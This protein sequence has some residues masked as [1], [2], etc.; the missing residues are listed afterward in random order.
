MRMPRIFMPPEPE[1]PP[2]RLRMLRSEPMSFVQMIVQYDAARATVE[3]LGNLGSIMF[4]DMNAGMNA[5]QR[6]FVSDLKRCDEVDRHLRYI[7]EQIRL[8]GVPVGRR[9]VRWR[10]SLDELQHQLQE[11]QMKHLLKMKLHQ[12]TF[13]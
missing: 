11:Q 3:E 1:S 4:T 2:R 8:A 9:E 6:N 12:V 13:T 5:F 10:A 7:A